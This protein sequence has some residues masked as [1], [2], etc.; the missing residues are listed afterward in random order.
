MGW[1]KEGRMTS[2]SELKMRFIIV[3]R[4][5]ESA[6]TVPVLKLPI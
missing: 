6:G 4:I 2:E 3:R 1:S 5:E